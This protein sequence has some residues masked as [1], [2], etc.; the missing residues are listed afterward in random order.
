VVVAKMSMRIIYGFGSEI[1]QFP[2]TLAPA[3]VLDV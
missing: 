1:V 3:L 2:N